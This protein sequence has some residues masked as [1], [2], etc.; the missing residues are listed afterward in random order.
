MLFTPGPTEMSEEIRGLG[1]MPLPYFRGAEYCEHVARLTENLQYLFGTAATPL[2]VTASGTAGME[3]AIVNLF[4]PGDKVVSLDAGTFGAK[5]GAMARDLGLEVE[6]IV[7]PHGADPDLAGIRAAVGRGAKGIL[8]TAHETSTGYLFDIEAICA[9]LADTGCLTVVDGVSAIGADAFRMDAW[10]CDCAIASSQKALA[11]MPGL[12]FVAFSAR[13]KTRVWETRHYR[14]YLDART[15]FDNIGRGMLPFTP[16]MHASYQVGRA[17]EKIRATGLERHLA[18]I[19]GKARRFRETMLAHPGFGLF[20]RRASNALSAVTLPPGV[21]AKA[22]VGVLKEKHGAIL[23]LNPT[24]ADHFVRVSH[25]GELAHEDLARLA[26][27]LVEE[28]AALA[29][30]A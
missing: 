20:P 3:M 25:M 27:W 2:T 10:G 18:D 21:G 14:S 8:L 12:V 15:Y 7:V 11:C 26:G 1:A 16:A 9:A 28:A 23:P 6:E 24:G 29:R 19:A 22:L 30:G 13:A 5:W 17:L 4:N